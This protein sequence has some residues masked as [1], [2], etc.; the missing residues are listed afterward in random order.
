MFGTYGKRFFVGSNYV[1]SHK[2]NRIMAELVRQ[3]GDVVLDEIYVPLAPQPA[4]FNRAIREIARTKP[5]VIFST[6][7][8]EGTAIWWKRA[9]G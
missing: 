4:D 9:P 5:D 6:V 1:Y 3:A 7:V 2:S 8:G